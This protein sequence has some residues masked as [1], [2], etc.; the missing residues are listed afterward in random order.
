MRDE[1][2]QANEPV[3]DRLVGDPGVDWLVGW[4]AKLGTGSRQS[5]HENRRTHHHY[6]EHYGLPA[7]QTFELLNKPVDNM[8]EGLKNEIVSLRAQMVK[9]QRELMR[10]KRTPNA[11]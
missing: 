8:R 7:E 6:L 9:N 1:G 5:I 4:V 11:E 3:G 10:P 2:R